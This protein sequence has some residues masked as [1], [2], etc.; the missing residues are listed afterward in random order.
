M[1]TPV[2]APT[3]AN[4]RG[5]AWA[6][7][8]GYLLLYLLLDWISY[9]RPLQGFNITPW[10]PQPALAIALLLRFPDRL[11]L[12]WLGLLLAETVVRGI[13]GDWWAVL[14]VTLALGWLYAA[15]ARALV[16]FLGP[17]PTLSTPRDLACFTA[18]L[19]VGA[20]LCGLAYVTAYAAPS[21]GTLA[22]IVGAIARYWIGDLVGLLVTL[23]ILLLL[24]DPLRRHPLRQAALERHWL[25]FIALIALLLWAVLGHGGGVYLRFFYLLFIPVVLAS[26]LGGMQG[27]VLAAT[28]TQ[29]GLIITVRGYPQPDLTLFELQVLMAAITMTGL[30]VGVLVDERSRTAEALRDS[31]RLATAGQMAGALAHELSQPLTA[32]NN[33]AQA[34]RMLLADAHDLPARQRGPLEEVLRHIGTD[35]TRAGQVIKRLRDFFRTGAVQLEA[36]PV[37]EVLQAALEA[38]RRR[39]AFSRVELRA[40]LADDLPRAWLDPVQI[41]IVLRNL[42]D[43]ALHAAGAADTDGGWVE[44]GATRQKHQIL[45]EVRDSGPGVEAG[46]LPTLFEPGS[47][48]KPGGMGIGLGICRAIIE[49]HGGRLWALA[50][51]HGHFCFTLPLGEHEDG[52]QRKVHAG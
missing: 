5:S 21:L 10:N 2:P 28:L 39:A 48:D 18:V 30:L 44:L 22:A 46:R 13:P 37:R 15:M 36:R 7:A 34:G 4:G 50:D 35:V 29:L 16:Q 19:G 20:L 24:I 33:Y 40:Q 41:G 27:A 14:V 45:V 51:G 11:W 32:L 1:T 38:Q 9:I 52:E 26:V 3:R 31:M 47:S 23:P 43:N 6:W 12:V 25:P 17:A 42:L 8:A 49:G